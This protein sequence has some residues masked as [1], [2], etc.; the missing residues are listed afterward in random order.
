[1]KAFLGLIALSTI[2]ACVWG[3]IAN[4]IALVHS[5]GGDFTVLLAMRIIGLFAAPL[6]VLLGWFW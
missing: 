6:G 3:Y 2:A 4:L 1:M 5:A